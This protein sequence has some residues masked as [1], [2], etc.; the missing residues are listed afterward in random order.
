MPRRV[1]IAM[2]FF[3]TYFVITGKALHPRRTIV[4]PGGEVVA[5]SA[6]GAANVP[7][8]ENHANHREVR[9]ALSGETG[10]SARRSITV[11]NDERYCAVPIRS[12]TRI[13]G[14]ARTSIPATLFNRRLDRGRAITWGAGFAALLLMLAG[15]TIRARP[16]PGA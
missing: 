16:V 5:D 12:G 4:L 1:S 2:K 14:V 15:P 11:G 7:S 10:F 3:L 8:M 13:V 9:A 6:M